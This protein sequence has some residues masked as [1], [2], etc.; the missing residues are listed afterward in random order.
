MFNGTLAMWI[1]WLLH[2][3]SVDPW[4]MGDEVGKGIG[5]YASSKS[6]FSTA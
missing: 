2:W 6:C 5:T 1:D 4:G 3:P